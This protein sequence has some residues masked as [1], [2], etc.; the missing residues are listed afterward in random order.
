VV[1]AHALNFKFR[2]CVVGWWQRRAQPQRTARPLREL[3]R[4]APSPRLKA[5]ATHGWPYCCCAASQPARMW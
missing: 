2:A 5:R 4:A 3:R 1:D